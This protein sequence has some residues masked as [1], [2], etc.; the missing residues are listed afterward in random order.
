MGIKTNTLKAAA[1][2]ALLSGCEGPVYNAVGN[3]GPLGLGIISTGVELGIALLNSPSPFKYL[4]ENYE[5]RQLLKPASYKKVAGFSKPSKGTC[6]DRDSNSFIADMKIME[7]DE[8][9]KYEIV[10]KKIAEESDSAGNP[11]MLASAI[12][13]YRGSMTYGDTYFVS[14]ADEKTGLKLQ[15]LKKEGKKIVYLLAQITEKK[16]GIDRIE[17]YC[18]FYVGS[19]KDKKE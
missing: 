9:E 2:V 14:R 5:K 19:K 11:V 6:Y 16:S 8:S 13:K 17:M 1:I 15:T 12:V 18:R 4:H 7:K 10:I 3:V